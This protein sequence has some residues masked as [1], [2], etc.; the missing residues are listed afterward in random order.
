[1]GAGNTIAL[2]RQRLAASMEGGGLGMAEVARALGISQRSPHRRLSD[3]G[4]RSNDLVDQVRRQ[5]PARP[6][7][8]AR[9]DLALSW[10]V[11]RSGSGLS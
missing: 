5:R 11:G 6:D 2:V 7:D 8:A 1:M 10:L 4:T 3:E 9:A